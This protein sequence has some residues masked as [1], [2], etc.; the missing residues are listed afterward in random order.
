MLYVLTCSSDEVVVSDTDSGGYCPE[1]ARCPAVDS[2]GWI[3]CH[4]RYNIPVHA[5]V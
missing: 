2:T 1:G 5:C 3:Q 4:T